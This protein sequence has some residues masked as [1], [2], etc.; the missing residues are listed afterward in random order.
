MCC[1]I[2]SQ[3]RLQSD[4]F[5]TPTQ[6]S[7][8]CI[9]CAPLFRGY[10]KEKPPVSGGCYNSMKLTILDDQHRVAIAEEAV[11][12]FDRFFIGFHHQVVPGKSACHDK[13]AGFRQVEVGNQ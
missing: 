2:L 13:Q 12:V 10:I 7:S 6:L 1:K 4:L 5:T 9:R 3:N 8:I 11:L